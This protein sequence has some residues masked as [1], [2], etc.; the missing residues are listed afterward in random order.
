MFSN[1][2][3]KT[4]IPIEHPRPNWKDDSINQTRQAS[5]SNTHAL[6]GGIFIFNWA[7]D[8]GER[9]QRQEHARRLYKQRFLKLVHHIYTPHTPTFANSYL[10]D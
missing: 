1:T 4:G 6:T 3:N 10:A 9:P 7:R 8:V 2:K 5:Q